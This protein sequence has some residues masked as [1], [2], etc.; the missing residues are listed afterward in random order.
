MSEWPIGGEN[1]SVTSW[2]VQPASVDS[3]DAVAVIRDYLADII[4]RYHGRPATPQEV[5]LAISEDPTDDLAVFFTG[6][7][8]P[9]VEGCA[10]YRFV[11]P[12]TAEL[13][14]VYVRPEARGTGGGVALLTAVEESAVSFGATSIRLD[15]RADLVEA[16]ALYTRHGYR[17]VAP[18]N[19]DRYA[20][21]W[22]EKRL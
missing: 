15:T 10:G 13:K 5:D 19:H 17:E 1:L 9:V 16:R 21:H 11:N 4:A 12:G 8:G 6:G 3:P 18:F 2:T 22:F 14:R 7:R 20:E